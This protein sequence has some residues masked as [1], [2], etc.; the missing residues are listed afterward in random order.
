MSDV[1]YAIWNTETGNRE[2]W[3]GAEEEAFEDVRDTVG[4]FGR[5]FIKNWA[6]ACHE[7]DDVERIAEGD[8]LID[9]A[10]GMASVRQSD[11]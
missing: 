8:E 4:R 6:L 3:Y 7:G 10:F 1:V 2:G 5:D 11:A 9:R